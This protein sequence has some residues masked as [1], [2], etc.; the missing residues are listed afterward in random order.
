MGVPGC[1]E[2]AA[3]TPS[4]ESVRMVLTQVRSIVCS[5]GELGETVAILI[6]NQIP[7]AASLRRSTLHQTNPR[8]P[9]HSCAAIPYIRSGQADCR[10]QRHP[11][12]SGLSMPCLYA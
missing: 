6:E 2:L 1:P 7:F 9:V 8:W 11:V 10:G 5:T 4:M 12:I 3:W